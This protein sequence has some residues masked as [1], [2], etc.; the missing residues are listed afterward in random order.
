MKPYPLELR[1][2][3]VDAVDQQS[4]TIEEIAEI[5]GVTE[6]YIYKL[7]KLRRD[8]G[9]LAPRPHGGGAKAK[10]DEQ[11]LLRLA[12]LV[13]KFPDAT[14]EELRELLRR[15]CRVSVSTNTVW[16]ALQQIAFPLKKRPAAPA[17]R[18]HENVRP[19]ARSR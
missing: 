12:D 18:T 10:L 9:D 14:L 6:R 11:R 19:F 2:R 13:A 1:Q 3:I 15:R 7:L 17:K 8:A 5:F 16:R 4:D